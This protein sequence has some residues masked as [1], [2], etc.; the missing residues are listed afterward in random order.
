MIVIKGPTKILRGHINIGSPNISVLDNTVN[1]ALLTF[2][3]IF[4]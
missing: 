4:I 2:L 1:L 3:H